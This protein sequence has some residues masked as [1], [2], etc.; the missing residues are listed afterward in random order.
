MIKTIKKIEK[1]IEEIE[2]KKSTVMV[3]N[4]KKSITQ[5]VD[6]LLDKKGGFE[7][8]NNSNRDMDE[9]QFHFD[10]DELMYWKEKNNEYYKVDYYRGILTHRR[11]IG[12][13]INFAKRLIR[14]M[15]RFLIEPIVKDQNE[16]NASVTASINALCNNELVTQSFINGQEIQLA[17][18][19]E[20]FGQVSDIEKLR[21]II[22]EQTNEIDRLK[23]KLEEFSDYQSILNDQTKEINS[24]KD[25]INLLNVKLEG[26]EAD[27]LNEVRDKADILENKIDILELNFVRVINQNRK[28]DLSTNCIIQMDNDSLVPKENNSADVYNDI[29]Y[30]SFENH[31]RGLRSVIKK[32]Q[33]MYVDY[34]VNK[35]QIVDL[36]CGR[37]EFLELMKEKGIQTIGVDMYEE[38][39]EYCNFKELHA[40]KADAIA[41][42][43]K[44]DDDSIGGLFASQLIEHLQTNQLLQLCTDAYKK[45]KKGSYLILETPNP[46]SLS[47][48]INAFYVD[49]S[50]TKPVHPKTIEYFLN[51]AGFKDVQVVFTEQSKVGYRLPL[52]NGENIN[53]LSEFNDGINC[54]SDIIFGSQ[55][56][57]VIAKK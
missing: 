42:L 6:I 30:F 27:L 16:F 7:L 43:S 44:L 18:F 41:Y 51:Q 36:G 1:I 54:I 47:I 48:Y 2:P 34:F 49:P 50:H 8:I 32:N 26:Q 12:K 9:S 17:S 11:F 55:D 29:D 56:Y 23:N 21:P 40:V 53:N 22:D 14:K 3:S 31:F 52:L 37:G 15:V 20:R 4:G 38:F 57:A 13:P 33:E 28:I 25:K 35:G 39:V 24:L 5:V 46:T 45:L 10:I 19:N